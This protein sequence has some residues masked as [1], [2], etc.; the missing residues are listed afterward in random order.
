MADND[1]L[2]HISED[3]RT[4]SVEKHLSGTAEL[5][6]CFGEAFGAAELAEFAGR[7]HDIGKYSEGFQK[8]LKENGAKVDHSTAGAYESYLKKSVYASICIAG[9]HGGLPDFGTKADS[10]DDPTFRGRIKRAAR[11]RLP[12]YSRWKE[13][14]EETESPQNPAINDAYRDFFFVHM[15]YSC[16]VD[17]DFLDTERFMDDHSRVR[18]YDTIEQLDRKMDQH[19]ASRYPPQG[20]LNERRCAILEALQS[21]GEAADR[22]L[23]T[24]TVPTGGGKT[25]ASLAFALKH[26]LKHKLSRVIYVVP[27]TSIIEQTADTF[28]RILGAQNVLEQHSAVI[29]REGEEATWQSTALAK[30]SE[31]WDMPVIVTTAV[32]FFESLYAARSSKCRKLHNIAQS[33]VIFDEAQLLPLPRLIPCV[34]AIAELVRAYKVSA[35]LMSATPPALNELFAKELPNTAPVEL[36]PPEL[37]D[38]KFFRRVTFVKEDIIAADELAVRL[39][40]ISQ[41][42]CVVNTRR[43][44][45]EIIKKLN[46]EGSFHLSTLMYPAHRRRTLSI[47]RQR[48]TDALPC[49]VVSTSLIEAGVDVDFPAL[50]RE[51]AGLDSILQAAGRC[52]R[53]GKKPASESRVVIFRSDT[54]APKLFAKAIAAGNY[55]LRK[56]E[57]IDSPKAIEAYF[58]ELLGISGEAALDVGNIMKKIEDRLIPL[59]FRTIGEDFR[60]IDDISYTVYIPLEDGANLTERLLGGERSRKLFRELSQYSVSVYHDHYAELYEAGD[61]EPISGLE[62][63]AVLVN[64]KLY[65]EHTGL[66]LLAERGKDLIC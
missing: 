64:T 20:E 45:Q 56:H 49:R 16:L 48:L 28:R 8:R 37:S 51:Q 65:C 66:S 40:D 34:A 43:L 17:A 53:E 46:T 42:L 41:V 21:Q 35:V 23:F 52:N 32:S 3:G 58:T 27:Y 1:F 22:G 47:I 33:V 59:P 25:E 19:T 10:P 15:L 54:A 63:A 4:Q 31:N 50:Y 5:A 2:A 26:A 14:T 7:L 29:Y 12:D 60:L 36:C 11:G 39:N 38:P 6:R 57:D 18:L 55:V 62:K 61:I 9:H 24:L 13:Y 30:A 44:A